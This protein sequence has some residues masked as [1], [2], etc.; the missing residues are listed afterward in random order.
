MTELLVHGVLEDLE[1]DEIFGVMVGLVQYLPRRAKVYMPDD[2]KWFELFDRIG[3]IYESPIVRGAE[4]LMEQE[5]TYSPELMPL[6]ERWA[7]GD[8]LATILRDIRCRTDLAGDLVG[9]FRRAKD[10]ISQLR[11]VH[12]QDETR[13]REL[14]DLLRRVTRDEVRVLD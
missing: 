4:E 11:Q 7:R 5:T 10:L 9:G 12:R 2:D 14:T 6:G 1:P 8:D 3:A 13:W